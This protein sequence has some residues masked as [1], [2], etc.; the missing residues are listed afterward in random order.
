M[1]MFRLLNA[2]EI[3]VRI[4]SINDKGASLLLYKDARVD[5]KILD[6]TVGSMNWKK[7]YKEIAGNLYC[8]LSIYDSNR[9]EWISK[10]D[11]G[12][13]AMTE[14]V[15]SQ[16]SDSFKRAAVAWGIGRELYTA[17]FIWVQADKL[18]IQKR[19]D[20]LTCYDKFAVSSIEYNEK[21]EIV[22][23]TIVKEDGGTVFELKSKAK[24][25]EKT[26]DKLISKQ[27]REQLR[28][29]LIRTQVPIESVLT[30]YGINSESELTETIFS[31]AMGALKKTPTVAPVSV[32][33]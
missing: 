33:S 13:A 28:F 31:K 25:L 6:E 8:E 10:Q 18:N 5:F 1:F 17:P 21:R 16:A 2:S 12:T 30:R 32:A 22:G 24:A 29:E 15:K 14:A 27:Q 9:N 3:E 11:V 20:K 23:L 26:K 4:S 7:Q 19:G